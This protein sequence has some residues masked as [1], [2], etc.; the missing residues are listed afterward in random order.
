[1]L[2]QSLPVTTGDRVEGDGYA[3]CELVMGLDANIAICDID[4]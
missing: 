1:M 3:Y 4:A 2:A